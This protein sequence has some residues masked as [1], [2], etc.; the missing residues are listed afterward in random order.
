MIGEKNHSRTLV[1]VEKSTVSLSPP[2]PSPLLADLSY[3]CICPQL[4]IIPKAD[5]LDLQRS[6]K[7]QIAHLTLTYSS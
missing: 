6:E 5:V 3:S 4:L 2:L 7:V 1:A